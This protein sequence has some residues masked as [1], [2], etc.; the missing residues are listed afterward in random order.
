M[1]LRDFVSLSGLILGATLF[2][3][4]KAQAQTLSVI[5]NT[6]FNFQTAIVRFFDSREYFAVPGNTTETTYYSFEGSF[7]SPSV[8]L[9]TADYRKELCYFS[10]VDSDLTLTLSYN[11]C[12]KE[13]S[14]CILRCEGSSNDPDDDILEDTIH[15]PFSMLAPFIN[16]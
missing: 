12:S 4:A 8:V 15:V 14:D 6:P 9:T 16:K 11:N 2:T 1:K 3:S 10:G 13:N 5:N 7:F